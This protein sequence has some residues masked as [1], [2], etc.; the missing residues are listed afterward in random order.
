MSCHHITKALHDGHMPHLKKMRD[1]EDYVLSRVDCGLPSQTSACQAGIMFGDNYDIPSFRWYDKDE[2][3][4]YVS[5]KDAAV[6]NARYAHGQ[7]LMRGGSSINNMLAGDAEKSILTLD[8]S[9]PFVYLPEQQARYWKDRLERYVRQVC[10]Q[11]DIRR[12]GCMA[13]ALLRPASS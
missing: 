1:E 7:G 4:L 8:L 9:Q 10:D 2:Q 6:L 5:G 3:K 11:L 13:F 12:R